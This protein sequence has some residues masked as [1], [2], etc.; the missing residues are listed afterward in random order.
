MEDIKR[1]RDYIQ[2]TVINRL[3]RL[4][5][6]DN[7]ELEVNL[8]EKYRLQG[9]YPPKDAV[10]KSLLHEMMVPY[11]KMYLYGDT[12]L[13]CEGCR[14]ENIARI[15]KSVIKDDDLFGKWASGEDLIS[16]AEEWGYNLKYYEKESRR[17]YRF[18]HVLEVLQESDC[19]Q[20]CANKI[21]NLCHRSSGQCFSNLRSAPI[22]RPMRYC[23]FCTPLR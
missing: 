5:D 12:A 13:C 4:M 23:V 16:A 20:D 8:Y 17:I 7:G 15:M 6:E 14:L 3:K 1:Y 9:G 19:Q 22:T 2:Y 11:Y 21:G 10:Y 18:F